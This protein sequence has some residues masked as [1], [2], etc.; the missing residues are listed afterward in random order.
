MGEEKVTNDTSSIGVAD[1]AHFRPDPDPTGTVPTYQE[2]IQTSIKKLYQSH[3][4]GYFY[5]GF[6]YLTKIE[7]FI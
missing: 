7:T 2:L 5:V 3:F 1:P 4:F 6:F